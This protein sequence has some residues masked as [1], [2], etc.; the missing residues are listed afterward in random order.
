[1]SWIVAPPNI[2][3]FFYV[4]GA[5]MATPHVSAVAA[6]MLRKNPTLSQ[7]D[8]ES[9]LKSTALNIPPGSMTLTTGQ[10]LSG[11]SK[12][13]N[14]TKQLEQY[15]RTQLSQRSRRRHRRAHKRICPSF[16]FL[17]STEK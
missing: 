17:F 3:N 14:P 5:S 15:K 9:V 2:V 16:P 7:G 12:L 11:N 13:P 10:R 1:M 8:V 4:G 6:L